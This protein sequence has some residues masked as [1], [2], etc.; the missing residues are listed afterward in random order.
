MFIA[1]A[2]RIPRLKKLHIEYACKHTNVITSQLLEM[3][4]WLQFA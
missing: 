1:I 4:G 3:Q 2:K